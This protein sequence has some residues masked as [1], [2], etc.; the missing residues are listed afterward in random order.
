MTFNLVWLVVLVFFLRPNALC[1]LGSPPP[2]VKASSELTQAPTNSMPA[3]PQLPS[4][5]AFAAVA[6]LFQTTQGQQVS[7]LMLQW[8]AELGSV[9]AVSHCSF[10]CSLMGEYPSLG[11]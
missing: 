11:S 1:F 5:D 7:C 4:S 8:L 6:Q 10:T 9:G 2:P 3:V